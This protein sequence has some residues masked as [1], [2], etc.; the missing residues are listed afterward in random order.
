MSKIDYDKEYTLAEM[1][2][3]CEELRKA[4]EHN[5]SYNEWAARFILE[6]SRRRAA[7]QNVDKKKHDSKAV[8]KAQT[9]KGKAPNKAKPKKKAQSGDKGTQGKGSDK[10]ALGCTDAKKTAQED[11]D[12][13]EINLTAKQEMFCREY[14]KDYNATRAAK[15][16]GYS[17][18]TA[19]SQ[20]QRL[21]TKADVQKFLST[22]QKPKL[23]QLDIS[24]ERILSEY[25]AM[26]FANLAD[27]MRIG[28]DG[29]PYI[30]MSD[31]TR[32]QA[33][34]L[35]MAEVV[36]LPPTDK[37]DDG[38]LPLKA[39]IRLADKKAAL[40]VL[41]K[42]AGLLKEHVEHSGEISVKGNEKEIAM[43]IAFALRKAQ[44]DADQGA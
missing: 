29:M 16:A 41:A 4:G 14:I 38:P 12:S 42:R 24:A 19:R 23:E 25:A 1:E 2:A 34:G 13:A 3:M 8:D 30:D 10:K 22:L 15:D 26:A 31:M 6:K 9:D 33:A 43:R 27:Y 36:Q 20:G 37:D 17:E 35:V 44:E 11:T 32:A 21:L 18:K 5:L 39:K 40:D 28:D 7:K